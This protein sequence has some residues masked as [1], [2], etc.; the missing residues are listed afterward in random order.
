MVNLISEIGAL[1]RSMFT[2]SRRKGSASGIAEAAIHNAYAIPVTDKMREEEL[3]D[4]D[5]VINLLEAAMRTSG[6]FRTEKI[7]ELVS[8]LRNGSSP[9]ARINTNAAFESDQ[10]LSVEEKRVLGLNTRMKYSKA[11]IECF[12][13][14]SLKTI[15]PKSI[16]EN[17]HVG[18]FH[19]VA[20][21]RELLRFRELGFVKQIKIIPGGDED[22][23]SKIRRFRKIHDLDEAPELPLP[24]C[25]APY[26]RCRYEAILPD[27]I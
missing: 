24:G 7:P 26:C 13:P 20:R 21:K 18:A 1:V 8:A 14:T 19:R 9:F 22:D 10:V 27:V 15:E 6:F 11:F 12:V 3:Q 16:L 17:M 25:T 23:C 4:N 2:G 5:E